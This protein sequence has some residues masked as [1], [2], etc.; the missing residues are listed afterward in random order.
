MKN[1]KSN[2]A[3]LSVAGFSLDLGATAPMATETPK[4]GAS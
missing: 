1:F 2:I 4:K 3:I